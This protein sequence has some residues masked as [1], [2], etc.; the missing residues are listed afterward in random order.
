[1]RPVMSHSTALQALRQFRGELEELLENVR[2][3]EEAMMRFGGTMTG[4]PSVNEAD[5]SLFSDLGPQQI[6]E[7]FLKSRPGRFLS[8]GLIA[9]K[10]QQDGYKPNN[11]KFWPTQVR[12]CLKR[13]EQK[14]I[15]E[16]KDVDGKK[17]YGLKMAGESGT[18]GNGQD[19][20]SH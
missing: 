6:V 8:S 14:G 11:P 18:S 13:A 3:T 20:T 16:S 19:E 7:R 17:R 5:E 2:K 1:M 10:I 15:A 12:N 4:V 9:K